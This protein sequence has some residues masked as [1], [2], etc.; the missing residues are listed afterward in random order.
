CTLNFSSVTPECPWLTA[1]AW[2]RAT[3]SRQL[4]LTQRPLEECPPATLPPRLRT[5]LLS[6]DE[7]DTP[8]ELHASRYEFWLCRQIRKRLEAGEL[9]LDD[10]LQHH[11]LS[12]ELVLVE[13]KA[14]I[15]TQMDI[16]FLRT[17]IQQQWMN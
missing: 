2:V 13:E 12:D 3:F 5:W 6:V 4:R 11:H 1:L 17:P 15:L 10:S 14:D 8:T 9:Y 16:P 7:N